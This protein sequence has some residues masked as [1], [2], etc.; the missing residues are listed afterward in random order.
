MFR[1]LLAYATQWDI[2]KGEGLLPLLME[3]FS[4]MEWKQAVAPDKLNPAFIFMGMTLVV[5]HKSLGFE[6]P[7]VKM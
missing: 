7:S 3:K 2:K 4:L 1:N 5:N 6:V